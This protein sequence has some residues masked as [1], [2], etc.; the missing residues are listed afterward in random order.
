MYGAR[1]IHYSPLVHGYQ[2]YGN[3]E[4]DDNGNSNG[5]LKLDPYNHPPSSSFNDETATVTPLNLGFTKGSGVIILYSFTPIP[6]IVT[7]IAGGAR[8]YNGDFSIKSKFDAIYE[9]EDLIPHT[10]THANPN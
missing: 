3:L 8:G 5:S 7:L 6:D 2:V 9:N 1:A 4:N 10:S